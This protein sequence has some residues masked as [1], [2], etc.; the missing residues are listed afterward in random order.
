MR[1]PCRYGEHHMNGGDECQCGKYKLEPEE[2][3]S[4][5]QDP[6]FAKIESEYIKMLKE[7][8]KG[9]R[10]ILNAAKGIGD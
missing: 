3:Y 9:N 2:D 7:I 6:E 4:N 5:C 8:G 1:R 10:I